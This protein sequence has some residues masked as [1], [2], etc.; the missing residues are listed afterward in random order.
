[1]IQLNGYYPFLIIQ[2][3]YLIIL[4]KYSVSSHRPPTFTRRFF[5]IIL[6]THSYLNFQLWF[7][8]RWKVLFFMIMEITFSLVNCSNL[9]LKNILLLI[10]NIFMLHQNLHLLNFKV[11]FY[12]F[13]LSVKLFFFLLFSR[14]CFGCLHHLPLEQCKIQ[15]I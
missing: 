9:F 5:V 4:F 11:G 15:F 10:W 2:I 8:G 3:E 12:L 1:M 7:R 13:L 6:K 14:F